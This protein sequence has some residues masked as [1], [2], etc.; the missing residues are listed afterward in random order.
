MAG[1]RHEPEESGTPSTQPQALEPFLPQREYPDFLCS[2]SLNADNTPFPFPSLIRTHP[3]T[4]FP[5][6][7][8]WA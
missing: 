4:N 5:E 2:L 1:G 7:G 6:L 3:S 8:S